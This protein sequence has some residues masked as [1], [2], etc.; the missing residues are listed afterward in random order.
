MAVSS[1]VMPD[2]DEP[3]LAILNA[4][5]LEDGRAWGNVAAR[6]Q[7]EDAEAIFTNSGPRW[8][9]LTRAR[10]GSKSTDLAGIAL[11]WLAATAVPGE[12]GYVIASDTAQAALLLDAAAG[13]A[14]RTDELRQL[15]QVGN[16]KLTSTRTGASVSVL[17]SDGASAFGLRPSLMILDEFAQWNDS[18]RNVRR[19]WS[20]L[21]SSAHKVPNSRLVI[22]TSAGEP[23][24]MAYKVLEEARTSASWRVSEVPGPLPWVDPAALEAQRPLLTDSEFARLHLNLW[25]VS[26]DRLVGAEDLAAAACL[27]GPQDPQPG[28]KYLVTLDLGLVNDRAVA[29]VAHGERVTEEQGSPVRVVVDRIARWKGTK[30]KPVQISD[31]EAWLVTASA[32]YHARLHA[33]PWQA[34]GLLQRLR[35]RGIIAEEFAFSQQSVGR[36]GSALHL[37]LRNRLIWIPKDDVLLNELSRVRLR[38]TQPGVIRLDHDA[39]EHDD[40][41]VAI[42][43]ACSLL[44]SKGEGQGHAFLRMWKRQIEER[45]TQNPASV[46]VAR[47]DRDAVRQMRQ[48]VARGPRFGRAA[49]PITGC[50]PGQH[51]WRAQDGQFR[52]VNCNSERPKENP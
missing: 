43:V 2:L 23:G 18:T 3:A 38:E 22:I 29:C 45:E 28:I 47:E 34:A 36:I 31:V 5:V 48:I 41:A 49:A 26:E 9:Y 30:A 14:G 8:H 7:R 10:G 37:A 35:S 50:R 24:G 1:P 17:A 27:D 42:A 40:Q 13:L 15:I 33:D 4:L 12:R 11:A 25:S 21:I 20:A 6:F 39:G 32:Q 44:M 19:L 52:C 51:L 16:F 46:Q